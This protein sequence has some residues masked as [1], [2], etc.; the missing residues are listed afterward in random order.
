MRTRLLATAVIAG[1]LAVSPAFGLALKFAPGGGAVWAVGEEIEESNFGY[2]FGGTVEVEVWEGFDYGLRYYYSDV[3]ANLH[4]IL[5]EFDSFPPTLHPQFIHHVFQLTNAWSP[6]WKWVD[7]YVRGS[8]GLYSWQQLDEDGNLF[9]HMIVNEADTTV[10][11][12]KATSFGIGL[13][14]GLRIWPT[15]FLGFRLGVDYDLIFSEDREK[16]GATDANENLLRVGG[17]VIFRIPLK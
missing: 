11:E 15:E 1:L 4:P 9:E 2:N 8:A 7:P 14:G 17:E 16:F 3:S 12:L 6:G 10:N 5:F 13:G